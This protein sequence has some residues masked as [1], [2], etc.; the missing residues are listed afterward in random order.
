MPP[1]TLTAKEVEID[2]EDEAEIWKEGPLRLYRFRNG[3][4]K[5]HSYGDC[6]ILKHKV[7]GDVRFLMCEKWLGGTQKIVANFRII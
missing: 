2:N 5:E 6:K 1:V 3:G 7:T 4:W